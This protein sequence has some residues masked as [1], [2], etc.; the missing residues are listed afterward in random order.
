MTLQ[1]H[2]Y[3]WAAPMDQYIT[4]VSIAAWAC[5]LLKFFVDGVTTKIKHTKNWHYINR[6]AE[7]LFLIY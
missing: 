2:S 5:S 1:D 6:E 4:L 3:C 7:L